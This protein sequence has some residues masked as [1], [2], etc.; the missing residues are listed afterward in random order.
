MRSSTGGSLISF[1]VGSQEQ[2]LLGVSWPRVDGGYSKRV[3]VRGL[4]V[5]RSCVSPLHSG[6]SSPS[7]VLP[8]VRLAISWWIRVIAL[9][10]AL[11][12]CLSRRPWKE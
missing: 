10:F 9:R 2:S 4:H 6:Y 5:E 8:R 7:R 3:P 12:L 1:L 11:L